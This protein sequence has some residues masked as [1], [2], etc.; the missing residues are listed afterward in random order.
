MYIYVE[1]QAGFRS[2]IGTTD[3]IFVLHNMIT[4][5]LNKKCSLFCAFVN[6]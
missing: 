6:V 5:M 2:N 4:H 1:A 3:N